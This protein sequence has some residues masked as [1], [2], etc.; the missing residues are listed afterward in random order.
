MG[1]DDG[2]YVQEEEFS[3]NPFLGFDTVGSLWKVID[4]VV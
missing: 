3:H 4:T 2:N 1:R